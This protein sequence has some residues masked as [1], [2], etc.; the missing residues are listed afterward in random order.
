MV[1]A[2]E[3]EPDMDIV[4]KPALEWVDGF[5]VEEV[6]SPENGG[7]FYIREEYSPYGVVNWYQR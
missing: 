6:V 4:W 7:S 5:E 2:E 3:G 1:G